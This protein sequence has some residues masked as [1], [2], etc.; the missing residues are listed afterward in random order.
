MAIMKK[1]SIVLAD[2]H[3]VV[4]EGL[5]ALLTAEEDMEI[6][7]EA[8]NGWQALKLSKELHPEVVIMDLAMPSLNGIEATR[9]MMREAPS[10]KVLA[11]TSY[12][13]DEHIR[14]MVQAGAAGYLSKQTAAQDLLRAIREV[15]KGNAFFSGTIA[16][17]LRNQSRAAAYQRGSVRKSTGLTEREAQVLQLIA[18]GYS[19]KQMGEKLGISV[20]RWR[21]IGSSL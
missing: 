1:I 3:A 16:R 10:S 12:C 21:S 20:R 18:D 9:R 2:D 11:L 17:R 7:G 8:E 14:D 19:N 13:N 5:R 6:V 15:Q 4:R